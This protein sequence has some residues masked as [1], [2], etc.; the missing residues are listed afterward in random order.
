MLCMMA[1]GEKEGNQSQAGAMRLQ[2]SVVVFSFQRSDDHIVSQML[3]KCPVFFY[4]PLFISVCD[5]NVIVVF[6]LVQS[7]VYHRGTFPY[8]V[9]PAKQGR[10]C[11]CPARE[12]LFI[13]S[14]FLYEKREDENLLI[15]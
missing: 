14:P 3:L 10:C 7:T 12:E 2:C 4:R 8:V 13:S 9:F 15:R 11:Y 6:L 5:E 1:A